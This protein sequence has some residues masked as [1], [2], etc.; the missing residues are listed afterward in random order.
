MCFARQYAE[1]ELYETAGRYHFVTLIDN[2]AC[3]GLKFDSGSLHYRNTGEELY[4]QS[5]REIF[6]I[7]GLRY[8]PPRYRNADG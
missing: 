2:C 7:L 4:P 1:K 3:R 6:D 5:E 8:V